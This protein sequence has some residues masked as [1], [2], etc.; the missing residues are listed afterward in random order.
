MDNRDIEL[1]QCIYFDAADALE[2]LSHQIDN[3]DEI[4]CSQCG[5]EHSSRQMF[6]EQMINI[7]D[8]AWELE[9]RFCACE[10][11]CACGSCRFSEVNDEQG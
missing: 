4:D 3:T 8:Q 1:T 5:E 10:E 7:Q 11:G 2:L 6:I 9:R